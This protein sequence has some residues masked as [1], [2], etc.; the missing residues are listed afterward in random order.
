MRLN[1]PTYATGALLVVLAIGVGFELAV[2]KVPN[3]SFWKFV[4]IFA[5]IFGC[6]ILAFDE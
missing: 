5:V 4:A 6:L 2:S 1:R 3:A